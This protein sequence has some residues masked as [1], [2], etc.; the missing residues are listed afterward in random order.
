[1]PIPEYTNRVIAD[2]ARSQ[3]I[4]LREPETFANLPERVAR[5]G[6]E[7]MQD[8]GELAGAYVEMKRERDAGIVDQFLNEFTMAKALKVEE[9]KQQYNGGNAEGIIAAY[10]DWQRDY[11]NSRKGKT[12]DDKLYLENDE[13]IAMVDKAFGQDLA[14][15]VNTM[16]AYVASELKSFNDKQYAARDE[17]LMDELSGE[18]DL[19]N[20]AI[21]EDMLRDNL[22]RRY[23]NQ[24]KDFYNKQ[25]KKKMKAAISAN[26]KNDILMQ[27]EYALEKLNNTY[28]QKKLGEDETNALTLEAG[29][30][31]VDREIDRISTEK[32]A[33]NDVPDDFENWESGGFVRYR[34]IVGD[35]NIKDY[36]TRKIN[37]QTNIKKSNLEDKLARQRKRSLVKLLQELD[38]TDLR[39]KKK[40]ARRQKQFSALMDSI[41]RETA[42]SQAREQRQA[43]A[44]AR[45]LQRAFDKSEREAFKQAS[46]VRNEAVQNQER[47]GDS[48]F[49]TVLKDNHE[50]APEETQFIIDTYTRAADMDA[51]EGNLKIYTTAERRELEMLPD[52]DMRKQQY[53]EDINSPDYGYFAREQSEKENLSRVLQDLSTDKYKDF[54][55]LMADVKDMSPR[56]ARDVIESWK[57]DEAWNQFTEYALADKR[58]PNDLNRIMVSTL[59]RGEQGTPSRNKF[60]RNA[61]QEQVQ[62]D[63]RKYLSGHPNDVMNRQTLE[64]I[65]AGSKEKVLSDNKELIQL[66]TMLR[67]VRNKL[68]K[69]KGKDAST[70]PTMIA[71]ELLKQLEGNESFAELDDREL[72]QIAKYLLNNEAIMAQ[73]VWDNRR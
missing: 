62:Y 53:L 24:S 12:D 67:D 68:Y 29:K 59:N 34:N 69:S 6:K 55:S 54:A 9:L 50:L 72:A 20:M 11:L 44:E 46:I 52:T 51:R 42:R 5:Q 49:Q 33:G 57:T 61:M 73:Y 17:M 7:F 27:P 63:I 43:E 37:Q 4:S 23:P 56:D 13:Q 38:K 10:N 47:E 65:M 28:I 15:S 32:A 36:A 66:S 30:N 58:V 71:D 39:D 35:K 64:Q 18:V 70:N 14:K 22:A 1:M 26:V 41:D 8:V 16:S 45:A 19:N 2:T 25:M 31:Y 3:G 40:V 48:N 60:I 21:T